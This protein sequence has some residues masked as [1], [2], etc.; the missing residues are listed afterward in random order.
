MKFSVAFIQEAGDDL[1]DIYGYILI[2][3]SPAHAEYVL[4]KL[5][6]ACVSLDE[7][8]ERGHIPPELERIGIIEFKEIHFKP[9]RIIY[10][11]EKRTVFIHCILDG[12]RDLQDFLERRLLR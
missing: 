10:E 1:F 6:E 8:P 3:D 5:Q 7:M 9:Y 2:N 11:I 4:L 12:R